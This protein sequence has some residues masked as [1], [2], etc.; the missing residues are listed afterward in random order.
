MEGKIYGVRHYEKK[1]LIRKETHAPMLTRSHI[2]KSL[3]NL[4]FVKSLNHQFMDWKIVG[5]YYSVYH[6][7]L[8]LISSKGYVSKTHNS[9]I[10]FLKNHFSSIKDDIKLINNLFLS[11]DEIEFYV[12]LKEERKKASYSTNIVFKNYGQFEEDSIRFF[13]KV[14]K[15]LKM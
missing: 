8:A 6:A 12:R 13:N 5:L 11:K 4:D 14:R 10:S 7:A 15:I 3:H 2:E 9:T 1:G